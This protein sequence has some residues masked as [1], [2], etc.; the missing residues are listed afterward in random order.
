MTGRTI[1]GAAIIAAPFLA[2][3]VLASVL[4]G[5]WWAGPA[6][7]AGAAAIVALM[8]AGVCLVMG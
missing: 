1:T 3:A 5:A 6:I 8:V 7:L 2:I 4:L